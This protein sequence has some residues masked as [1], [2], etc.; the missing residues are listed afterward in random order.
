MIRQEY[1]LIIIGGGAGGFA[2]AIRANALGTKTLMVNHGLPPGGTCVNVG[3][4]PSKT[5]LWA[6]EVIH[7]AKNHGIPGLE[8]EVKNFDFAKIV[9]H[10]LD[11]VEKLRAEKY[12]KV[13]ACLENVSYLEGGASFISSSQIEVNNQTYQAKKFIIA[14]GSTSAVP[15]IE[16][17]QDIGYINHIEALKLKRQPGEL[18]I[19]GAGPVGLEFAQMYARFG[20]KVTMLHRSAAI[21]RGEEEL[22]PM[23]PKL[24]LSAKPK[25]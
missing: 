23:F 18:I 17:I 24:I 25:D 20:T 5:L 21:F 16:N 1:D 22:M 14:A 4:V 11:L 10:E 19:V 3:C 6:G 12:Q 2:A 8:I 7:L 13:L 15:Q 9:Q